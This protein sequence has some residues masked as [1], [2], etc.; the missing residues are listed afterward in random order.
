[1]NC[2]LL[3]LWLA[4]QGLLFLICHRVHDYFETFL[5]VE[6]MLHSCVHSCILKE[7]HWM[8]TCHIPVFFWYWTRREWIY[9]IV[10]PLFPFLKFT[11]FM[12]Q[13]VPWNDLTRQ[14][15]YPRFPHFLRQSYISI[16][17]SWYTYHKYSVCLRFTVML[18]M[19][20]HSNWSLK[21]VHCIGW[22]L[23]CFVLEVL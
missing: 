20:I 12:I 8:I 15:L 17:N 10:L 14:R 4:F 3:L 11:K 6:N 2:H 1:M 9:L 16:L 18:E 7:F 23:I 22:M 13:N 21:I 19:L 5:L